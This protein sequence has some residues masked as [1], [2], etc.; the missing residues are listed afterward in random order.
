MEWTDLLGAVDVP[1]LRGTRASLEQLEES[2]AEISGAKVAAIALADPMMVLRVMRMANGGRGGRFSQPVSTIEHALMMMGLSAGFGRMR[3][4]PEVEAVLSPDVHAGLLAIL[5]QASHAAFQARDWAFRRLD[6]NV[7]EVYSAALLQELAAMLLWVAAPDRMLALAPLRYGD[8]R[9]DAERDVLGCTLDELTFELAR[10]WNLP[11]LIATAQQPAECDAHVRP[12][13]VGISRRLARNVERGWYGETT[14]Q[15]IGN[16]AE[17]LKMPLDETVAR[18]HRVAVEAARGRVFE[19]AL[20]A[21]RWLPL[22][23][24]AWPDDAA[25]GRQLSDSPQVPDSAAMALPQDPYQAALD[26]IA[27][28][29]DG[30]LTL[31]ELMALVL[32]GM[33]DGIGLKRI[34]FALPTPDRTQL[35]ARFVVGVDEGSPLKQFQCDLRAPG[36]MGR[37]MEKQQAFW[38]N[39]TTRSKVQALLN[40]DI[41]RVVG[42]GQFYLMSVALRG[43]T[44]GLFYADCGEDALDPPRYDMFKNLCTQAAS[45]MAHLAKS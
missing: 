41:R 42:D 20:P 8:H 43:R 44:V 25:A 32:K 21:A 16:V 34:V 1:V 30:T 31:N 7:E 40:E 15:D 22:L 36:L 5:A 26:Q 27:S 3:T 17:I 19:G 6:M 18:V 33:R 29:L 28:H 14:Q 13:L 23:P 10:A 12:R 11:A 38:L 45:G 37:I 9:E 2:G 24:G 39:E 4:A 35:R